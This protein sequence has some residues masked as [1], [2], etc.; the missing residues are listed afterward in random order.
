MET[1]A[2]KSTKNHCLILLGFSLLLAGLLWVLAHQLITA[3]Y[4]GNA[5]AL[6]NGLIKGQST[7]PVGKY[8]TDFSRLYLAFCAASLLPLLVCSLLP[9]TMREQLRSRA[10]ILS[11]AIAAGLARKLRMPPRYIILLVIGIF[12][13]T[14]L[15]SPWQSTTIRVT[16]T[17]DL[18]QFALLSGPDDCDGLLCYEIEINCKEL[19]RTEKALLRVGL[20]AGGGN[21]KGTI[22]FFSGWTGNFWWDWDN[23]TDAADAG[24]D[25][26]D[27]RIEAFHKQILAD[28]QA[29]GYR[30][31]QVKWERGWFVAAPGKKENPQLM[32]C[33]P[34][35]LADWVFREM[36]LPGPDRAF[37]AVGHSN[38]ATE[39]GYML[40]RY[41]QEELFS[42]VVMESG[43]NWARLDYSCIREP[44]HP[45][46]FNHLEGRSTI[47]LAFGYPNDGSGI[48][49]RQDP[50][51]IDLFRRTSIIQDYAWSYFYP[52]T[53][54][55]IMV[56]AGD[57]GMGRQHAEYYHDRL[58]KSGSPL[59]SFEV[60]PG[61]GHV[62]SGEP[63]GAAWLRETLLN[64][65]HPRRQP[66]MQ[67]TVP[68]D[69][70]TV[71]A[72]D[73]RPATPDAISPLQLSSQAR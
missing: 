6:L 40:S 26:E 69:T 39:L 44:G 59:L 51:Q 68:P 3:I 49:A 47:D 12:M 71:T 73:P 33:N 9:A 17:F 21:E 36:H 34:A 65:C 54:I 45:G 72:P 70:T 62:P 67:G 63:A 25:A 23:G 60:L 4:H 37:C 11:A 53:M 27:R 35:T 10:T 41:N 61:D 19:T 43:P 64:E 52:D 56:S 46:L 66:V 30:T 15:F 32:A 18:G 13:L 29:A 42:L 14:A 48:C 24:S 20:P 1:P 58:L 5:G 22:L 55:A 57:T 7:H 50:G 16:D 8:L 31:V 38:G 2:R 28:L